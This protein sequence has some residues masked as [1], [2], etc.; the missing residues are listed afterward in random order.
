[1]RTMNTRWLGRSAAVATVAALGIVGAGVT[2]PQASAALKSS[3]SGTRIEN[4]PLR[5]INTGTYLGNTELWYSS[6]NG[7]TNCV[8]THI[9]VSGVK[10]A[11]AVLVVQR[12]GADSIEN[13][14]GAFTQYAGASYFTNTN[15]HCIKWSGGIWAN[16]DND[17]AGSPNTWV[18]CG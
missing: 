11:Q 15:G 12:D 7:G 16:V 14:S 4:I 8:I 10:L 17:A 9:N 3:C 2:A 5:G 6:A 1:M 18:H 13:N